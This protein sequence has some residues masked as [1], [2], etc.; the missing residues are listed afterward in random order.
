VLFIITYF[1]LTSGK[2][3]FSLIPAASL[4]FVLKGGMSFPLKCFGTSSINFGIASSLFLSHMYVNHF[5]PAATCVISSFRISS[6]KSAV[7][8]SPA[9]RNLDI[10]FGV[11]SCNMSKYAKDRYSSLPH[12]NLLPKEFS[13]I[14]NKNPPCFYLVNHVL[15]CKAGE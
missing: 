2:Y 10:V 4:A 14:Q 15:N 5:N 9:E 13:F 8:L 11:Y 3:Q 12:P 6:N 1:F 7:C